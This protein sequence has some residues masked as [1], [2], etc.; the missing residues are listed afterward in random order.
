MNLVPIGAS[1][2]QNSR[3]LGEYYASIQRSELP[4]MLG[5]ELNVDDLVRRAVIQ[6]WL[7]NSSCRQKP[8]KPPI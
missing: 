6:A 3:A 2:N 8:L 7:V 5:L 4:V 1:Y